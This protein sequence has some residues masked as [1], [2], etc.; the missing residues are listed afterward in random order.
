MLKKRVPAF[1][2]IRA[3]VNFDLVLSDQVWLLRVISGSFVGRV[4][5]RY[6]LVKIGL[7]TLV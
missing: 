3:A 5:V 1:A 4:K 7:D 6:F 2:V